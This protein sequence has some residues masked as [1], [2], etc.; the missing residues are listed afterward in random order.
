MYGQDYRGRLRYDSNTKGSYGY[1]TR[2]VGDQIIIIIIEQETLEVKIMRGIGHMKDR[3]ETEGT[4]EALVIADQGQVQGQ[5][6]TEIG[7]D[8]LSIGNMIILQETVKLD[9]QVGKQNKYNKCS[10][11]TKINTITN[12]TDGHKSR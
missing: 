1:N 9:K 12:P 3:T 4:I 6:Q 11:W 8:A 5:L 2:V 10:I 7:L